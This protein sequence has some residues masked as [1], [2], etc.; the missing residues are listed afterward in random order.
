MADHPVAYRVSRCG[1]RPLYNGTI[2]LTVSP[3]KVVLNRS[4]GALESSQLQSS[5]SKH[6]T[7][8]GTE[9]FYYGLPGIMNSQTCFSTGNKQ[10]CKATAEPYATTLKA[11]GS[12]HQEFSPY[13]NID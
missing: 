8:I 6:E 10:Y 5:H 2:T 3:L 12:S 11:G 13:P 7:V 4:A 9:E 1:N